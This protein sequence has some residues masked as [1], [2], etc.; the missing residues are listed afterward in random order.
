MGCIARWRFQ[1]LAFTFAG[2]RHSGGGS[3]FA[4][5]RLSVKVFF[6]VDGVLIDGWHARP[7]R[8]RRWD[9]TIENDLG[10]DRQAFQREFFGAPGGPPDSLMHACI[11]GDRDLKEVLAEVLPSTG[12]EG[13]VDDFVT[14]WFEKD[15][16]LN[17][18]VLDAVKRLSRHNDLELYLATAQEHHR[19]AYLWN[20]L[21][22][23]A[24]FKEIFY[25]AKLGHLK[26]S[27]A[28]FD[29]VNAMLGIRS[30]DRV[31]F[32]DDHESVVAMA[33]AAGWEA[34]VFDGIEDL[35]AHPWLRDL[36]KA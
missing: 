22:L 19:A 33:R 2:E 3:D 23:R 36:L 4:L 13:S 20:D 31:L 14:Y 34:C 16:K 24:L 30:G 29:K 35:R 21:D 6:D 1:S 17:H 9:A 32:F 11:R 26:T 25:S 12:Y 8:R 10:F 28:F 18:A 7:E 27:P 5:G 15:S